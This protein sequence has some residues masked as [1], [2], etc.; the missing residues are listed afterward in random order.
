MARQLQ[1]MTWYTDG[2]GRY[3][4]ITKLTGDGGVVY[5]A[6]GLPG[7]TPRNMPGNR[8][9][10]QEETFQRWMD[11]RVDEDSKLVSLYRVLVPFLIAQHDETV[12]AIL[13]SQLH[14]SNPK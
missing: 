12:G 6:I 7:M 9:T 5:V 8:L 10:I 1:V 11:H 14:D 13:L 4:F 3:R 2:L